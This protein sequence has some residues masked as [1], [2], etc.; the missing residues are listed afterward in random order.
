MH[1]VKAEAL[2]GRISPKDLNGGIVRCEFPIGRRQTA[3]NLPRSLGCDPS[4]IF[5]LNRCHATNAA[6]FVGK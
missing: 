2:A 5:N 3:T 6:E 4:I 1:A